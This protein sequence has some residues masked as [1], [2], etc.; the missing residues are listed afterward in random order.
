[1]QREKEQIHPFPPEAY[2]LVEEEHTLRAQWDKG[3]NR[4]AKQVGVTRSVR[5][6]QGRQYLSYTMKNAEGICRALN[7]SDKRERKREE[8]DLFV[9][10][11]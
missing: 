2:S 1:M 3:D 10:E 11:L 8:K 6:A 9:A 4:G 7:H 5:K